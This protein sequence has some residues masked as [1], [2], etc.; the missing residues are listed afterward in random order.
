MFTEPRG[1]VPEPGDDAEAPFVGRRREL[2]ALIGSLD[3]ARSGEGRLDIVVGAPGIGKTRLA[4]EVATEASKRDMRVLR[5]GCWEGEGAPAYW[6]WSDVLR[7]ALGAESEDRVAAAADFGH[8]LQVAATR[9]GIPLAEPIDVSRDAQQARFV[10]FGCCVDV[11]AAT[12]SRQPTL[13][14][15]DDV[16]WADTGSLLLLQFLAAR[17]ADLPLALL[18]TSR[19][20]VSEMTA[21]AGRH[22]WA[23]QLPL[24]GLSRTEG[25]ALIEARLSR[26]PAPAVLDRLMRLTEGN[27]FFL[28][29]LG[30]L[31]AGRERARELDG[32]VALPAN[33]LLMALQ[34]YHGLSRA[35]RIVLQAAAVIGQE[36]DSELATAATRLSQGDVLACMDEAV[37]RQI[38]TPVGAARYRFRH[39]LQREAIDGQLHPSERAHLHERT[40][41]ALERRAASGQCVSSAA[42]AHHFYMGLPLTDRHHAARHAVAAGEDAHRACAFEE[43]VVQLRRALDLSG[44]T[45]SDTDTCDRLLLLGA[46]EAGAGEWASSR[47]T[48]EDAAALARRVDCPERLA[49]AA[50]GFKGMM[51]ATSPVDVEAVSL[52]QEAQLKLAQ[53]HP[54]LSVEL[55]SA[56]GTSLYFADDPNLSTTHSALAIDLALR[57]NDERLLGIA[58][59]ARLLAAM[60][61]ADWATVPR[62]ADD[63]LDIGMRL[64]NRTTSFHAR[65]FR[66][67][68]LL[69]S[70]LSAEAAA[71]L[72]FAT[73]L[74]S[75][76]QH[77]RPTW[78]VELFRASEALSKGQLETAPALI[79]RATVL[80]GRI[81]DPSAI[82]HGLVQSFQLAR[83]T[84]RYD[85]M[86]PEASKATDRHPGMVGYTAAQAYL[87]AELD[88]LAA[89]R[90]ILSYFASHNFDNI[91]PDFF[92]L[93]VYSLLA[94]TVAKC[95]DARSATRLFHLMAP[96][97]RTYIVAGWGTVI[98]G[99]TAH[100]LA[101]L[102]ATRGEPLLAKS[103]F[104]EA[105]AANA[106]LNAPAILA[107]TQLEYARLLLGGSTGV[108]PQ[109]GRS[110]ASE[111]QSL[112]SALGFDA[113]A[114]EANALLPPKSTGPLKLHHRA[115]TLQRCGDYWLLCYDGQEVHLQHRIGLSY[116]AEILGSGGEP[117]HVLDLAS[118][119]YPGHPH[120]R[121]SILA[122]DQTAKH[123]YKQRLKDL[124][125]EIHAAT[126]YNDLGRLEHLTSER[127]ALLAELSYSY[128]LS[129]R[130]RPLRSP[131]ER[132]RVS[133]KNRITSALAAIR[134]IHQSAFRHLSL[135]IRTGTFCRYLPDSPAEWIIL[136]ARQPQ[137]PPDRP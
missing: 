129:G 63:L 81:H 108:D 111:A 37:E 33:V 133:V 25:G 60:R 46:A 120:S 95:N 54:D 89:S 77:P 57:L 36:F 67:W 15:L 134:P 4:R 8:L 118:S 2:K 17:L 105:L 102:A 117:V 6:P 107:R 126:A 101:L 72:R 31:L 10:L 34:P 99:S 71:E 127:D 20:P 69:T 125:H 68:H 22:A 132:A 119:N 109:R 136:P 38:V 82:Q 30:Q 29:E 96:Y 43:A 70:G 59:L 26:S 1:H 113:Y 56:L 61:P 16:H 65:I 52:L 45:C 128:D 135:S 39:A 21:A 115:N 12:A 106:R 49:R 44:G 86:I 121:N 87:Y 75:A 103:L 3:A 78:Q 40:A 13:V 51:L 98:D 93:Y 5:A 123:A 91:P 116:I 35:C 62:D 53:D 100:Y 23:R 74:A 27:P 28:K 24:G 19:E 92:T 97:Q 55:L 79:K 7:S 90:S 124:Q 110:L 76:I 122:P 104:E 48:F 94:H 83:F 73:Q 64:R 131:T 88:Q 84:K 50:L 42:L 47:R 85:G 130:G 112:F 80:G 18:I 14:V 9:A 41:L 11:L 114:A 137:R 32:S 66:Y 58:L